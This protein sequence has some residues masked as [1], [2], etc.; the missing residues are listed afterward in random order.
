[1][2]VASRVII[3]IKEICVFRNFRLI[4]GQP[5]FQNKGLKEPRCMREMPLRRT[6]VRDRLHNAIL[7]LK[8]AAK[9]HGKIS[10]LMK[11]REQSL[12]AVGRGSL[13]RVGG[14]RWINCRDRALTQVISPSCSSSSLRA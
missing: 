13:T 2:H 7:G 14:G 6:H 5:F 9:F 12:R 1:M 3:G 10:N 8:V 11:T 4:S